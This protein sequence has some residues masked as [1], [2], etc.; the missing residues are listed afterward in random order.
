MSFGLRPI[1]P[2]SPTLPGRR[3][4]ITIMRSGPRGPCYRSFCFFRVLVQ[5]IG[6][7]AELSVGCSGGQFSRHW[8]V[9]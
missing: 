1:A 6:S 8:L 7:T 3:I 5:T 4:V 2:Y 9:S